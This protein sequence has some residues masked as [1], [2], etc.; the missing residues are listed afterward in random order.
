MV[1]LTK[2]ARRLE[3]THVAHSVWG[4]ATLILEIISK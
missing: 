3:M 1:T 2:E 4:L